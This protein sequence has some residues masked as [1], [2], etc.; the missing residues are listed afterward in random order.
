MQWIIGKIDDSSIYVILTRVT[1]KSSGQGRGNAEAVSSKDTITSKIRIFLLD[2]VPLIVRDSIGRFI[3][4]LAPGMIVNKQEKLKNFVFPK[5]TAT[6]VKCH[7]AR[8]QLQ[9]S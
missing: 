9:Q 3:G 8:H 4:L 6:T 5:E 7:H 2:I 1:G